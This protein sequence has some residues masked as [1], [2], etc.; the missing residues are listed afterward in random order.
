MEEFFN[1][2]TTN[3]RKH[4]IELQLNNFSV[5][6]DSWK[7]CVYFIGHTSNQYVSMYALSTIEVNFLPVVLCY[8]IA[9]H[10]LLHIAIVW[11]VKNLI[12]DWCGVC[13]V[14][15]KYT[16]EFVGLGVSYAIKEY[17]VQ[18]LYWTGVH[19][20]SFHE[21]QTSKINRRRSQDRL[22][23]LL[24][25]FFYKHIGGTHITRI[26]IDNHYFLPYF[27]PCSFCGRHDINY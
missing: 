22:A 26:A 5:Q 10:R 12:C 13:L 18:V 9:S 14:C 27:I 7:F 24:P 25:R 8:V 6:K 16:V 1:P 21:E 20:A 23:T 15:D 3:N 19:R 17:T 4:D 11:I 2:I